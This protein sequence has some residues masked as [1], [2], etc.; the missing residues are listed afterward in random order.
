MLVDVAVKL[1][2]KYHRIYY[3]L[4][5]HEFPIITTGGADA[6]MLMHQ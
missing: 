3:R 1:L 6:S 5:D 2:Y 4:L